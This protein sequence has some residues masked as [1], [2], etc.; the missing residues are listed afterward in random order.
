MISKCTTCKGCAARG[1]EVT[2]SQPA[3]AQRLHCVVFFVHFTYNALFEELG[4]NISTAFNIF[5]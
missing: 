2:A 1:E 4:M 5:V 3:R